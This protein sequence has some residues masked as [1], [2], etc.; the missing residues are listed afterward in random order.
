M[1]IKNIIDEINNSNRDLHC[2]L[3]DI[4]NNIAVIRCNLNTADDVEIC[5]DLFKEK[6]ATNWIVQ[7]QLKNPEK[8]VKYIIKSKIQNF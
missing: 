8:F 1:D 2:E 4:K 3:V 5:F 7:G 6:S